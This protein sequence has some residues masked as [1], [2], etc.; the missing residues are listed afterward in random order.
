ML[1]D[2]VLGWEIVLKISYLP[3]KLRF[4]AK[5]SFFGQSFSRGHYQPTYQ[6]PEGVY[7]LNISELLKFVKNQQSTTTYPAP[8]PLKAWVLIGLE[9]TCRQDKLWRH[10][11]LIKT[12]YLIPSL[13][14]HRSICISLK[15]CGLHGS[16]NAWLMINRCDEFRIQITQ[17]T[18]ETIALLWINLNFTFFFEVS[19]TFLSKIQKNKAISW[20]LSKSFRC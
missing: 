19:H 8:Q 18:A 6:P 17:T 16:V 1:A 7:L 5:Y 9:F 13:P 15:E 20:R 12:V 10:D 14:R 2:N 3:S 11:F 4:S